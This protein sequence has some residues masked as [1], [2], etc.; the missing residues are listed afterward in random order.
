MGLKRDS[1]INANFILFG[2]TLHLPFCVAKSDTKPG[3]ML[4]TNF[5]IETLIEMFYCYTRYG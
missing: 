1:R 5:C 3:N 2:G 4:K